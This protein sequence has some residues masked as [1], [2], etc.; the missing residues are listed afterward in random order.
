MSESTTLKVTPIQYGTA[1]KAPYYFVE[2][3]NGITGEETEKLIRKPSA[4]ARFDSWTF[5]TQIAR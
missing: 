1:Q 5:H 4:L 2:I 3:P